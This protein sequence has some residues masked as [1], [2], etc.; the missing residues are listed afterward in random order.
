M[1]GPTAAGD[2]VDGADVVS[3]DEE[4]AVALTGVAD[5]VGDRPARSNSA[6]PGGR[7]PPPPPL[8]VVAANIAAIWALY[9]A[10]GQ[11]GS[12]Q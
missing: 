9:M 7:V 5:V 1:Y 11:L 2:V 6:Y 4:D 10:V 12:R 8:P 3:D